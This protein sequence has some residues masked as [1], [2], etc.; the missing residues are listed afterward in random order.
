MNAILQGNRKERRAQA[1][2]LAVENERWPLKMTG[3][4][5]RDWPPHRPPGIVS[6][7]RSRRFLAQL[8][9][10]EP[11]TSCVG[12]LSINR[13]SVRD[14]RWE[15]DLTWDELMRVKSECGFGRICA[16]E[17]YPAD[18]KV[19]NVANMRHLWLLGEA[20]DFAWGHRDE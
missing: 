8:Y 16:V 11:G 6:V 12:R 10:A 20:P 2:A 1:K 18:A 15:G 3:V 4:P 14:S 7:W 9:A 5:E 17:V 19:V 13:T